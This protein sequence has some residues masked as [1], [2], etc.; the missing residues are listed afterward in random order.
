MDEVISRFI[1]QIFDRSHLTTNKN[2]EQ[3]QTFFK[4]NIC[5]IIKLK[6]LIKSI[7]EWNSDSEC[8]LNRKYL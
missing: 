6:K 3:K 4:S 2:E 8:F 1:L 5:L 7:K